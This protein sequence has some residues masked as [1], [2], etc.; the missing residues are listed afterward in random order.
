[1]SDNYYDEP[2]PRGYDPSD[3][4]WGQDQMHGKMD[5]SH[6]YTHHTPFL[7]YPSTLHK[8]QQAFPCSCAI[9]FFIFVEIQVWEG[10]PSGSYIVSHSCKSFEVVLHKAS[11]SVW[12]SKCIVRRWW[13]SLYTLFPILQDLAFLPSVTEVSYTY[14]CHSLSQVDSPPLFEHFRHQRCSSFI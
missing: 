8:W 5:I 13:N 12:S 4:A 2:P 9:P 3:D 1:M 10:H 14:T 7:S 11:T 6:T